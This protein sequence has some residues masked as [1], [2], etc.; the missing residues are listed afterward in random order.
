MA[1][2]IGFGCRST[3]SS[4]ERTKAYNLLKSVAT[5]AGSLRLAAIATSVEPTAATHGRK[6]RMKPGE[7]VCTAP[8]GDF[9]A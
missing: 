1:F 4:P 6:A 7:D 2:P 5:K 8:L 9:L 3:Q